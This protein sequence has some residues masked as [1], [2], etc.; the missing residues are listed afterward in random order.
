MSVS[1]LATSKGYA[2]VNKNGVVKSQ[3]F[4]V[5]EWVTTNFRPDIGW[6]ALIVGGPYRVGRGFLTYYAIRERTVSGAFT[7]VRFTNASGLVAT[8]TTLLRRKFRKETPQ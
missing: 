7:E 2:P 8:A 6:R 3:R 5:G 4:D 1:D